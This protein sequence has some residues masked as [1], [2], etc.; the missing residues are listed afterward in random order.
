[1]NVEKLSNSLL[2]SSYFNALTLKLDN[3]FISQLQEE[4]QKRKLFLADN[5]A[6]F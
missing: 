3:L 2:I 5:A 6:V 1:M 4:I